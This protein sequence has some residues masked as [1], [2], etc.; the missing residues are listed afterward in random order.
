MTKV[1]D[2]LGGFGQAIVAAQNQ[3]LKA[4]QDNPS[5]LVGLRTAF[6]ISETEIELK[7]IFDEQGG[8]TAIKPVSAGSSR[9][10]DLDPGVLSTLRAKI[11][12]VP[13]DEPVVPK[14]NPR[15]IS[16]DVLKRPDIR[17]LAT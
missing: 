12:V 7:L 10:Q 15:K 16:D 5:P 17:R 9:L 2:V 13:D 11:L 4:A 14:T 3:I 8:G 1:E 6:S